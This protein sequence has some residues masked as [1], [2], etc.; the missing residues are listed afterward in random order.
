MPD[1]FLNVYIY[2][3]ERDRILIHWFTQISTTAREGPS[4]S[5]KTGNSNCISHMRNW[6]PATWDITSAYISRKL[7]PGARA[8]NLAPDTLVWDTG[9]PSGILTVWSDAHLSSHILYPNNYNGIT[10]S[11]GITDTGSVFEKSVVIVKQKLLVFFFFPWTLSTCL[12]MFWEAVC[13]Y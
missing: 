3:F 13:L 2:L 9:I 10:G 4:Q 12:T 11:I 7:E 6:N 8:G 5:H 1:L